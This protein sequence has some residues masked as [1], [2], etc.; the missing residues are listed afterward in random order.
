MM[1]S[2]VNLRQK[3]V[4]CDPARIRGFY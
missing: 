4:L 3:C 2:T 1:S